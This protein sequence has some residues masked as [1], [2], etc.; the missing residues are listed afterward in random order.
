[1]FVKG[2]PERVL[3]MCSQ[4]L[5]DD[6]PVPL[7]ADA[8]ADAAQS[9]AA[10]GQRVLGFARR[11]FEEPLDD[12]DDVTEPDGLGVRRVAGDDRPASRRCGRLDRGMSAP[13]AS[14]W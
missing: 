5:T 7:D 12:P 8:V 2:A 6:G 14:A 1:M 11:T 9:M 3:G 4:M 10:R 13:P